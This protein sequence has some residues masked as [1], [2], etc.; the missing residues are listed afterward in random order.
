M[1]KKYAQLLAVLAVTAAVP[2][3]A[4]AGPPS[5]TPGGHKPALTSD[6][7]SATPS[8]DT[9]SSGTPASPTP[10]K[11]K[12]HGKACQGQSKKHVAGQKGTPFSQCVQALAKIANGTASTPKAAC[13]GLSK[14]HV[15]GQ[16]GT[17][18]SQCI[19]AA[20][21]AL[22]DKQDDG[23]DDASSAVPSSGT[24]SGDDASSATPAVNSALPAS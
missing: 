10:A 23:D 14:K 15:A 19:V 16:K 20:A 1:F 4:I 9:P 11:G 6:P 22:K 17:P 18:Y 5:G 7:S 2:A 3:V 13:K 21:Q 12:G 24:P 8:T